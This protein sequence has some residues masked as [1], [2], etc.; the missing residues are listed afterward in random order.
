MQNGDKAT[1][2]IILAGRAL[3]MKMLITLEPRGAFGILHTEHHFHGSTSFS[4]I[5]QN[6]LTAL[7]SLINFAYFYLT[8]CLDNG[9]QN[10][11]EAS[12]SIGAAGHG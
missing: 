7:Y 11:V 3:F 6:S 1:P 2:S 5:A 10:G 8:H 12:P 4:E 9:M